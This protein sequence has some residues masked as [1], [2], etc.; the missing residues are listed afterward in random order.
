MFD[1]MFATCGIVL[2][3]LVWMS[4]LRTTIVP[5][6]SAPRI[7]RWTVRACSAVTTAVA[8]KLPPR[9]RNWL[10]ELCVPVSLFVMASGWLIGLA[11]GFALLVLAF[12]GG[13]TLLGPHPNGVTVW[14]V[15][16]AA[17]S[18]VLVAAAFTAYLVRFMEA[19]ERREG[20][21][22]RLESQ[23]QRVTDSDA[24]VA[25]YLHAGSRESLDNCFAQWSAWLTDVHVS[26][27]SYP[28]LVYH[29]STGGLDWP[30]AAIAV[31]DAAALVEAVAPRWA[32]LHTQVLLEV[33]SHCLQCLAKQMGI[34]LPYM[35]ISLQGREERE[36]GDTMNLAVN[37]GLPAERNIDQ[38]WMAFQEI[39]VRYAPYAVQIG[40][41]SLSP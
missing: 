22:A 40:T 4:V 21:I 36:F 19:H 15:V 24:L 17:A 1:V 18:T 25:N 27:V 35:K 26:H 11:A 16:A 41:R 9:I 32:P 31:M 20:M 29:R 14:L 6:R 10:T 3:I 23:V 33:G 12:G 34:R 13:G 39:R 7:A 2:I 37:S 5:S 28:G 38:A 8:S 30:K